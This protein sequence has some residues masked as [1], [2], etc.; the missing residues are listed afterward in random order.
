MLDLSTLAGVP[1]LNLLMLIPIFFRASGKNFDGKIPSGPLS[2]ETS[3]T[4]TTPPR[5][6]PVAMTTAFAVY[7]VFSLVVSSHSPSSFFKRSIIS[8]C[9]SSR[10]CCNSRQCFILSAYARLSIWALSE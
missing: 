2:Y 3:P 5:Y 7:F 1:V 8:A 9:L 10:F 6:V 4:N